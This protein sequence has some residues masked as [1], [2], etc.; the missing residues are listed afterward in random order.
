MVVTANS[1]YNLEPDR[2][3]VRLLALVEGHA[4]AMLSFAC[5]R[6][7]DAKRGDRLLLAQVRGC[8]C[9]CVCGGGGSCAGLGLQCAGGWVGV[10]GEEG[11]EP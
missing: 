10:L 8:T 4:K 7:L 11:A 6:L 5:T 2:P 3:S 1:R 9:A